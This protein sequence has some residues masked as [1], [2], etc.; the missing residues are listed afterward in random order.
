M[1]GCETRSPSAL[2][3]SWERE[4]N[5]TLNLNNLAVDYLQ[6]LKINSEKADDIN[7]D[8]CN[9]TRKLYAVF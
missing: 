1:Y 5:L 3:S 9:K 2:Q 8:C 4:I 7:F 6:E